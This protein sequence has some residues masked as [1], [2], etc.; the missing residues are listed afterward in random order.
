[1]GQFGMMG[2]GGPGPNQAQRMRNMEQRLDMMQ[3][4]RSMTTTR[5]YGRRIRRMPSRLI[6]PGA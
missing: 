3:M 1:M 5:C 2:R 4:M 6:C